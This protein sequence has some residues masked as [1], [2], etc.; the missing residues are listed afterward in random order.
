MTSF[1]LVLITL[2][3]S[4][5]SG[6]TG[7]AG[8]AVILGGLLFIYPPVTA[9]AL[10]AVAQV[11]SNIS[12]VIVGWRQI[13]WPVIIRFSLFIPLFSY[14]GSLLFVYLN[15]DIVEASLGLVLLVLT[16][17]PL[18]RTLSNKIS[19]NVFILLGAVAGFFGVLAGVVGPLLN[20]FFDKLEIKRERMVA[21]KS[22]CMLVLHLVRL[23]S[24]G[25]TLS[26][27]PMAFSHELVIL[28]LVSPFGVWLARPVGKKLTDH[29]VDVIIK[30]L[31]T[32]IGLRSVIHGLGSYFGS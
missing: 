15:F 3:G 23:M 21:T 11:I 13:E 27:D 7:L 16:W 24:Y 5:L 1:L 2:L 19:V 12:R 8:G 28:L 14:L 10:H 18:P 22:L 17:L 4:L 6:L 26:L 25:F 31:L 30:I 29:Q 20:P 32:L 9:L